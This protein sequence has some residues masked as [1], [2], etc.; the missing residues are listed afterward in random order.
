MPTSMAG[1]AVLADEVHPDAD[2]FRSG[3]HLSQ[4]QMAD[5]LVGF[6][7]LQPTL[8]KPSFDASRL[9]LLFKEIDL[10][11]ECLALLIHGSVAIDLSHKTPILNAKL[12]A[13]ALKAGTLV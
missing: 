11:A 10:A 3:S 1:I 6:G 9:K 8:A 4:P 5:L 2:L 13:L 12:F 7:C